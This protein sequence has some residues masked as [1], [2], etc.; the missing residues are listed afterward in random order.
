MVLFTS[1]LFYFGYKIVVRINQKREVAKNTISIPKFMYQNI[2]GDIFTNRNLKK[3]TPT[4]FI[5]FN[6]ECELCIE[7]AKMIKENIELLK[8]FQIVFISFQKPDLIK[9]FAT[10]YELMPHDYVYFLWDSKTTFATTFDVKSLP[11]IVFYD[12]KGKRIETIN[13]LI[14]METLIKKIRLTN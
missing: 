12:K 8:N 10:K 3:D 4:L 9:A 5:Y 7:E 14:K 13:G 11:Y 6:T 1:T 2:K